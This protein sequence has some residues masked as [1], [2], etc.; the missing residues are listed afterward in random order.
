M[1]KYSKRGRIIIPEGTWKRLTAIQKAD[2]WDQEDGSNIEVSTEVQTLKT[3]T[4]PEIVKKNVVVPAIKVDEPIDDITGNPEIEGTT[5][6]TTD[7]TKKKG[8]PNWKKK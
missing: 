4:Q 2:F 8:N 7:G 6:G 3:S 5:E 1:I